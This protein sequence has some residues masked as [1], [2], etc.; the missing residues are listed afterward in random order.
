[1]MQDRKGS[2]PGYQVPGIWY[3]TPMPH[4]PHFKS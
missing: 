2:D 3:L 4:S 1:M